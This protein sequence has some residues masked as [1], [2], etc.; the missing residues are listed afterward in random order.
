MIARARC[1]SPDDCVQEAFVRLASQ[2]ALPD[3]PMAWLA[4]VTRNAAITKWRSEHRRQLHEQKSGQMKCN[5]FVSDDTWHD[6][7]DTKEVEL[8]LEALNDE[9]REIVVA[10]LWSGMTFRQ[11]AQAFE[12][13]PATAHRRYNSGLDQLR[14]L[15]TAKQEP[16]QST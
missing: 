6:G 16:K 7:L 8:A 9:V 4:T 12:L 3:D 14:I 1:Q 13:A 5:W 11:I 2:S 15:L 10:H